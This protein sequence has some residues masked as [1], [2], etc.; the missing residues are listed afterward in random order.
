VTAQLCDHEARDGG[1]AVRIAVE[2]L[3]RIRACIRAR[4]ESTI[5]RIQRAGLI[6]QSFA[7]QRIWY[8]EQV[9]PGTSMY[10]MPECAR[11][12]GHIDVAIL[13]R[14]L[15][16][17]VSRHEAWRTT[18]ATVRG[19]PVQ[20]VAAGAQ[21]ALTVEGVDAHDHDREA[22]A[23]MRL[24][25]YADLPFDLERGPLVR[26]HLLNLD[27]TDHFLMLNVHHMVS[28]GWSTG[29][30]MAEFAEFYTAF[31]EGK[32]PRLAELPIQYGDF[33]V[34]QR[35]YWCGQ[36]YDELM[37]YWEKE[38]TGLRPISLPLDRDRPNTPDD[39]G[40]F[41]LLEVSRC[42]TDRL[43]SL[44]NA[45]NTTLFI[46][47]SSAFKAVLHRLSGHTDISLGV[48][49]A[50]R[51][52]VELESLIGLFA[53]T[54]VLRTD[55][56][57]DPTFVELLD[58]EKRTALNAYTYQDAPF[59]RLVERLRPERDP[60]RNPLFQIMFILQNTPMPMIHL[61]GISM[62]LIATGT[63][64]VKFDLV[65]ELYETDHGLRGW[66]GYLCCLF[67]EGT[68]DRLLSCYQMF[69]EDVVKDPERRI[70]EV[71]IVPA[72]DTRWA[73][74]AF[75]DRLELDTG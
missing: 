38:L 33:A 10:N 60:W 49:V 69:L 24:A 74:A 6:P 51:G 48:P 39:S 62:E 13:R 44:A 26:M 42:L 66:A 37:S 12:Q 72:A 11:L 68:I 29:V 8:V 23:R 73:F 14:S 21:A 46:V 64:S 61:P 67:D 55:L 2:Q 36:R 30:F 53:N 47:L 65:F 56:S 59:E 5:P 22:E 15:N 32:E 50:G 35:E 34:W 19:L 27:P 75:T 71:R 18:F 4:N 3:C 41:K 17:I 31:K 28:D 9:V 58:R 25:R 43:K 7:Q 54:V 20:K 52:R 70:S 63:R 16:A 40:N 45:H 57:D 1:P